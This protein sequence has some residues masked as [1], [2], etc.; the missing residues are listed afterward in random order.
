[1][2]NFLRFTTSWR[3][4]LRNIHVFGDDNIHRPPVSEAAFLLEGNFI[5]DIGSLER[6]QMIE[7]QTA[8]LQIYRQ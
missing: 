7:K 5:L 6:M 8:L 1:M 3:I 2:L 4:P